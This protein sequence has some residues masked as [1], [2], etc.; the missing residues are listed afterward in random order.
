MSEFYINMKCVWEEIDF[1]EDLF[2]VN[3][4]IVEMSEFFKVL[5]KYKDD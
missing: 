5:S 3:F 1:M 4:V 2:K